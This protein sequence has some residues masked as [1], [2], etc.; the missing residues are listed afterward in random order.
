MGLVSDSR[1]SHGPVGLPASPAAGSPLRGPAP[2][3]FPETRGRRKSRPPRTCAG[4]AGHRLRKRV[5]AAGPSLTQ[6]G[7]GVPDGDHAAAP[8]PRD[9]HAVPRLRARQHRSHLGRPGRGSE[10]RSWARPNGATEGGEKGGN[11]GEKEGEGRAPGAGAGRGGGA[12]AGRGAGPSRIVDQIQWPG[13]DGR[14]VPGHRNLAAGPN[15]PG[16]GGGR[17]RPSPTQSD[18][19]KRVGVCLVL[20]L[21]YG[22]V[23][24]YLKAFYRCRPGGRPYTPIPASDIRGSGRN[25]I[26]RLMQGVVFETQKRRFTLSKPAQ[27]FPYLSDCRPPPSSISVHS[28]LVLQALLIFTSLITSW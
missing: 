10:G 9:S 28:K 22:D 14:P 12:R 3:P 15:P 24:N 25:E 18:S 1:A 6:G 4:P 27:G 7:V 17:L 20:R 26:K 11:R 23:R 2:R 5:P 8:R 13:K 19:P 16:R 21:P